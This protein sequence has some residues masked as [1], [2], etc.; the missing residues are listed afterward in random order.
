MKKTIKLPF[1]KDLQELKDSHWD[2]IQVIVGPR[3][4]GKTTGVLNFL[5]AFPAD[6]VHY[7][8]A[9]GFVSKSSGWINEQW[10]LAK[11]KSATGLLVIDEIQKIE[12]WSEEIKRLWDR[13]KMEK[14]NLRVILLGSSSLQ[15][16][17]GLSESLTGRFLLHR[18]HQWNFSESHEGY[19]LSFNQYVTFGGYPGSYMFAD[20]RVQWLSY[21]NDSIV[22]TVIGRD[23][24]QIARVKSPAL[25]RQCF[26]LACANGGQEISYNKL[27]GQLQDKGNVEIVKHYLELFEGAF[28]I[29]QLPKYSQKKVLARASSP[30]ILPLCPSLYSRTRDAE[31]DSESRGRAFEIMVG[32]ELNRLPGQLYY[33]RENNEEVDYVHSFGKNLLALE[34]KSGRKKSSKGLVAFL[35][36][37]PNAQTQIVTPENYIDLISS[38]SQ[39]YN[40]TA[41]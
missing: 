35:K 34:V 40:K 18:V 9:D 4:V 16:Q 33:W 26:E 12:N 31:L 15:I 7:A 38:M 25:F 3:Q 36:H 5:E 8:S 32:C 39:Q 14:T 10:S 23:I 2:L 41:K 1:I 13:Q 6:Q 11:A 21:M 22:E 29:K 19:G 24:L 30:K 27:L 37:F 17:K 20:H 28:L